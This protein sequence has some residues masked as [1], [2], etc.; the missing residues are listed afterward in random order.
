MLYITTRCE[1][2]NIFMNFNRGI[3]KAPAGSNAGAV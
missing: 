3:K 2:K 1:R